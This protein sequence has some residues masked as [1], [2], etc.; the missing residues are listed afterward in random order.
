M[1]GDGVAHAH[2]QRGAHRVAQ[3]RR[4]PV[5]QAFERLPRPRRRADKHLPIHAHH[6]QV[7]HHVAACQRNQA[8]RFVVDVAHAV[9]Q[10][11]RQQRRVKASRGHL[12]RSFGAEGLQPPAHIGKRHRLAPPQQGVSQAFDLVGQRLQHR[13][14]AGQHG[15]LLG[16][17]AQ[18]VQIE[19][20]GQQ[21]VAHF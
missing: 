21:V 17:G 12:R 6:R 20:A 13:L 8:Q 7:R 16:L 9:G 10:T 14:L 3:R 1:H 4:V 15:G 2:R 19:F 11:A 18:G 5:P